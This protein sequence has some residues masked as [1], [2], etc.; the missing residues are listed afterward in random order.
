[1]TDH[2]E[3]R[4]VLVTAAY[5]EEMYIEGLIKSVVAQAHKP[6]R[7]VIVSDSSTDR[8]DDIVRKYARE[9]E[10]IRPHRITEDHPRNFAA[11][12]NAINVGFS[13]LQN[14]EYEFIGNLDADISLP[15]SYFGDLLAK[16]HQNPQLGLGGAYLYEESGGQFRFR[17]GN[18]PKCVPHGVQLFRRE[19]LAAIGGRYVPFPYGGPDT[20]AEVTARMKGWSVQAFPDLK[21]YH[22][23]PTGMAEGRLRYCFRQGLM[24]HSLGFHP[25]FEVLRILARIPTKPYF[26]GSF[27]R[28]YGFLSAIVHGQEILVSDEFVRYS[29]KEQLRRLWPFAP[30]A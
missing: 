28:L 16:F 13:L 12:V 25:L 26:L 8:T 10:F 17:K 21:A 1:M 5:N 19:C 9:H 24:D 14:L 4:Y 20:H 18:N 30:D 6:L 2:I 22:H 27:L 29:Q 11:Q 3:K 7:W 23:R 15:P